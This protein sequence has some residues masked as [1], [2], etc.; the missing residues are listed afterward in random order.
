M[1]D[2]EKKNRLKQGR[3]MLTTQQTQT[4]FPS[5]KTRSIIE[6]RQMEG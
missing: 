1:K 3:K 2:T 6:E 4:S 5:G